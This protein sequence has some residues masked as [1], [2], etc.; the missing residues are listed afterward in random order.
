MKCMQGELY[1]YSILILD[2]LECKK[3]VA[4]EFHTINVGFSAKC[5]SVI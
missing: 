5:Y 4:Q 3:A 1:Y 2:T